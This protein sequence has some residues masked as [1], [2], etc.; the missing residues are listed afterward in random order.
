MRREQLQ[1][2]QATSRQPVEATAIGE[3]EGPSPI[4][5]PGAY[6]LTNANPWAPELNLESRRSLRRAIIYKELLDRPLAL[7][8]PMLSPVEQ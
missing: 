1:R 3:Q 5:A 4:E 8:D 7:R 2:R 6:A